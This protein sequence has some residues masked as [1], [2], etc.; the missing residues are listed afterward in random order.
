MMF[1]FLRCIIACHRS[2]WL[3]FLLRCSP[4]KLHLAPFALN[5]PRDVGSLNQRPTPYHRIYAPAVLRAQLSILRTRPGVARASSMPPSPIRRRSDAPRSSCRKAHGKHQDEGGRGE[6]RPI[7]VS[8]PR[9]SSRSIGLAATDQRATSITPWPTS[10]LS[11]DQIRAL[12]T[13]RT[14]LYAHTQLQLLHVRFFF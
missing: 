12:H 10:S 6:D 8:R 4:K 2:V 14:W 1:P 3:D 13:H 9:R 5:P 11:T 7:L